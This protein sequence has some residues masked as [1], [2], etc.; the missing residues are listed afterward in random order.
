MTQL[1]QEMPNARQKLGFLAAIIGMFMAILD[2]QIVASSLN[3]IQAGVSATPDEISWVQT[4]YLIAEVIMIPL[5]GML[6]RW[7][8]THLTFVISCV[9]FTLASIG[10]AMAQTIEQLIVLRAIQGF[11]GGAMIPIAYAMSFKLF[12]QRAMGGVQALIG[13][14]ATLAPSIG[15][16]LGG[17]ITQNASWHWLFLMNVLPGTLAALGVWFNLR[18]DKPDFSLF[19]KIDFLG[20]MFLALFLGPLE[21]ILEEGPGDD[22]FD[23]HEILSLSV[24]CFASAAL[25]FRRALRVEMPIVDIRIFKNLNFLI[26]TFLGFIIGIALYGLVYLVPLYL[27]TVRQFN[28]LQIGET[29]FVT[30]ATMFFSAPIIGRLSGKVDNRLMLGIGLLLVGCGALLNANLTSESDFMQFLLPQLV[31]GAG[32]LLCIITATNIAMG[33]LAPKDISNASGL[34]NVMR[35]LG[36]AVGLAVMDTIRDYRLDYHWNQLISSVNEGREVVEMQLIQDQKQFAGIVSDPLAQAVSGI[37]NRV[38]V[39]A[40]VLSFNDL[41]LGLGAIYICSLPLLLFMRKGNRAGAAGH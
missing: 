25:F 8:S 13:M 1:P 5:S 37:Y 11:V 27:G 12:P 6:T 17:Y 2:I 24:L 39:Q 10:C 20:L 33:T 4:A 23:S 7:L 15:P 31:R 22:W 38:L 21:F 14:V 36:G 18:I 41:F 16:T 40:Q 3:E 35:N 28:S 9:A 29:M 32:M 30:G 34:Y 26:G 19:K